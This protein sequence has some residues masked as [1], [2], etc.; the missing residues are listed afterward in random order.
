MILVINDIDMEKE[1]L[2]AK[3]QPFQLLCKTPKGIS[4]PKVRWTK[5]DGS[6]IAKPFYLKNNKTLS[7]DK[8]T[9][10]DSSS[11]KCIANNE[12]GSKEV[13]V[14]IIVSGND[15]TFFIVLYNHA[16]LFGS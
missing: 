2:V 3:G 9:L 6:A 7:I 10:N 4:K 5:A 16:V 1:H 14:Q 15:I 12:A 13:V 11:F 8:T